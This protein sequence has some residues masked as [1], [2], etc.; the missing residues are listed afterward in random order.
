[1]CSKRVSKLFSLKHLYKPFK[2]RYNLYK[3][4][5]FYNSS[6]NNNS[7]LL[8]AEPR[9]YN[10]LRIDLSTQNEINFEQQL[11]HSLSIWKSQGIRALW[12]YT[13]I[14]KSQL[15]PLLIKVYI[16]YIIHYLFLS[17]YFI[18]C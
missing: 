15:I 13:S 14:Y 5:I 11:D 8:Q 12:V 1:M 18:N 10:N 6:Y 2:S 7:L 9:R 16:N 3:I 17:I 4:S